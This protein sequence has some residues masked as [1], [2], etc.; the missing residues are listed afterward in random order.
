[1]KKIPDKLLSKLFLCTSLVL[2]M[3]RVNTTLVFAVDDQEPEST[4]VI[5]EV[6]TEDSPE[7]TGSPLEVVETEAEIEAAGEPEEQ[8][9]ETEENPVL[10]EDD[11][12]TEEDEETT[13][14]TDEEETDV[15]EEV[16]ETDN[17]TVNAD[18]VT[19]TIGD[20]SFSSEDEETSHWS[21]GTG[22]KN[23][24][25]QYVAMVNYDGSDVTI[26]ADSGTFTLA[27]AG[28]NKIDTLSGDCSIQISGSGI[29]LIDSIKIKK[30]NTITLHPNTALYSEGSA[31]IFLKQDDNSYKLI[32]GGIPG[33]LDEE[34]TLDNVNLRIPKDSSL[35]LRAMCIRTEEWHEEETG[36]LKTDVTYF[37]DS[38]SYE[39]KNPVHE[40]GLVTI[41]DSG[42]RLI[43][44]KNATLTVD[45]GGSIQLKNF[46]NETA[47]FPYYVK[48]EIVIHGTLNVNGYTEGGCVDISDGK[49]N[50]SGSVK[51]A[52]VT[53]GASG[54]LSPDLVLE[55]SF[56]TI[57][58]SENGTQA[59][60]TIKDSVIYLKG[61]IVH[62]PELNVSGNSIIGLDT[63]EESINSYSIG[64][65]TLSEGSDLSVLA[66]EHDYW[67]HGDANG[68]PDRL[69]EDAHLRI[70]GNITGGTVSVLAGCVEY[71]GTQTDVLPLVPVPGEYAAYASR[72]L[73]DNI[74]MDSTISPLN[75]T[76]SKASELSGSAEIPVMSFIVRD[77]LEMERAE[78][79]S[80]EVETA[81]DLDPLERKDGQEFTAR[82][83]LTQ[84]GIVDDN[85]VNMIHGDYFYAVE[86]I[87]ADLSRIRL[88]LDDPITFD[89]DDA[90]LIRA[91]QCAGKGGQGGSTTTHTGTSFTGNGELGGTGSGSV[92]AGDG[93]VIFGEKED[94]EPTPTPEP[95][96]EPTP[97]PTPDPTP[98][99]TPDPKPTPKP[100]NNSNTDTVI[101]NTT[102]TQ[103]PNNFSTA[104]VVTPAPTYRPQT[105][106]SAY[107]V[108]FDTNGGT[109]ILSQSV[110]SG[111][112]A[113]RPFNPEKDGFTFDGWY[114]D[115]EL[116]EPFDFLTPIQS[117]TTL[118]A[119]W[120]K[121]TEPEKVEPEV[122]KEPEPAKPAPVTP[123][124]KKLPWLWILLGV[125]GAAG[126]G[127]GIFF[128]TKKDDDEE[129]EEKE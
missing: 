6:L 42:A 73:V 97:Q 22:W 74:A 40:N 86:V 99:P 33:I 43:L 120:I 23:I 64:D 127:G 13:A 101:N 53:L 119:K 68:A 58:G 90:I 20:T 18:A 10:T 61:N 84:Y 27:V 118:Y 106:T 112:T 121:N 7:Q 82:S 123:E 57:W 91:L 16:E 83:F 69:L 88:W 21:N 107:T 93:K 78:A 31:A 9:L 66:N 56:L 37:T 126:A 117:N 4:P 75:V 111:G 44:G 45:D 71:D 124:K 98:R 38:I 32:N 15:P 29:V 87:Y 103:K 94:P 1:M 79:R 114:K 39:D 116:T 41:E 11:E 52:E 89:T 48:P 28:V 96:P 36:E 77:S 62:L 34:Y 14:D 67:S 85:T 80:W 95:T 59:S 76:S 63:E 49:L 55:D 122:T 54:N 81:W 125:L 60:P 5:E 115:E 46:K 12:E 72:V 105:T 65:I 104:A 110:K 92:Q 30:G 19:I 129:E 51:S 50:G 108:Y 102:G 17:T 35:S 8:E 100:D 2:V 25:G 47:L 70:S 26:S 113:A 109:E 128:F 3:V 24:P